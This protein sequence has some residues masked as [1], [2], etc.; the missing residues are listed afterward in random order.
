MYYTNTRLLWPLG[1]YNAEYQIPEDADL[2]GL[3]Y[4]YTDHSVITYDAGETKLMWI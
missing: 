3:A 4:D 2:R 1:S